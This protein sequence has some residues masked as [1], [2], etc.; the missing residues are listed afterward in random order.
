M[1]PGPST[2][3][4]LTREKEAI[5]KNEREN[6]DPPFLASTSQEFWIF[7]ERITRPI[8]KGHDKDERHNVWKPDE[9]LKRA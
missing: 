6:G 8:R 2:K 9:E 3:R 5:N 7:A 1:K 4:N